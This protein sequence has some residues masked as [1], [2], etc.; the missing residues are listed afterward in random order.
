MNS[1]NTT[2]GF[3]GLTTTDYDSMSLEKIR[4]QMYFD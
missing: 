2:V 4:E 1:S 3:L